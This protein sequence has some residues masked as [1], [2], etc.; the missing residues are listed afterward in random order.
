MPEGD[1]LRHAQAALAPVLEGQVA[2][3][4]WFRKIR[5]YRPRVG[6][7]IERVDAVGKHLL[8]EFDR[9]LTL[10]THL[11]MAGSWRALPVEARLPTTPT[12]R[13]VISTVKGHALCFS[14]PVIQTFLR[15]A[16]R[17]PISDLGPDLSDDDVD[18]DEVV[19]RT[20]AGDRTRTIAELL[21]DQS[22]AAGVGNVFKSEALFVAGVHP[23]RPVGELTDAMLREVWRIAHRQLVANR[24][25]RSRTTTARGDAGRTYVYG[26]KHLGC[27]RC[28]IAIEYSP[29]GE[30]AGRSTYWCP[31][32]Q[33]A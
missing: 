4:L 26:R 17:T 8:I 33:P 29:A 23:F 13:I 32:C 30:R 11:G 25:T 15:T 20:R 2:T 5:G 22:I 1:T 31:T 7:R 10:D 12:L 18:L 3:H 9:N 19:R 6:Q 24:E 28:N 21:L 14:A 16:D 27:R